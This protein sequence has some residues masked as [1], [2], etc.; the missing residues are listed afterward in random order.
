M[1]EIEKLE[2]LVKKCNSLEELENCL[3]KQNF[4]ENVSISDYLIKTA[5]PMKELFV[6]LKMPD[7][8]KKTKVVDLKV[9][10]EKRIEIAGI[11]D[12]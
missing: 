2:S 5:P 12:K 11:H 1:S 9:Y 7:G 4:I 10:P 8:S 3:K 6:V